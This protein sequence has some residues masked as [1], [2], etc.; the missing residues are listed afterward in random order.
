MN[1]TTDRDLIVTSKIKVEMILHRRDEAMYLFY[2]GKFL[3]AAFMACL[4][5]PHAVAKELKRLAKI[6]SDA[7]K[8]IKRAKKA[9]ERAATV[10]ARRQHQRLVEHARYARRKALGLIP[11]V[12]PAKPAQIKRATGDS[13]EEIRTF[14]A[15]LV[16]EYRKVRT[17]HKQKSAA[18]Q[19]ARAKAMR[20]TPEYRR[21]NAA[22]MCWYYHKDDASYLRWMEAR[23]TWRRQLAGVAAIGDAAAKAVFNKKEV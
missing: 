1:N 23:E 22:Y 5:E 18:A 19:K 15:E 14:K 9:E 10:G 2:T 3:K 13:P 16:E 20:H 8:R 7:K 12:N 17:E 21:M 4:S 11:G 6:I